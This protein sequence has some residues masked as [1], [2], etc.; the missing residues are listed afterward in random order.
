MFKAILTL[1]ASV[2]LFAVVRA[3]DQ[4]PIY[5][6]F[7]WSKIPLT[8]TNLGSSGG[9]TTFGL[10]DGPR[11]TLGPAVLLQSASV[12]SMLYSGPS[13]TLSGVCNLQTPYAVCTLNV[14]QTGD[15][16]PPAATSASGKSVTTKKG[17]ST[18]G[19][20]TGSSGSSGAVMGKNAVG[21]MWAMATLAVGFCISLA[22][23][24]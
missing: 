11:S 6:P 2:A 1:I 22:V 7:Q 8:A 17:G 23:L 5:V 13:G 12:G 16:L 10:L 18:S 21:T 9:T 3:Q 20:S 19:A 4:E 15:P 14:Q 24:R